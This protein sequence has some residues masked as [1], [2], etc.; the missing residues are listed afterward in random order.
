MRKQNKQFKTDSVNLENIVPLVYHDK[1]VGNADLTPLAQKTSNFQIKIDNSSIERLPNGSIRFP[2]SI[3]R[4]G[5]FSYITDGKIVR[6][7]RSPE[8]VF[9]P[10][11]ISTLRSSPITNDHPPEKI[12]PNNYSKFANGALSDSFTKNKN[13]NDILDTFVTANDN[14]L[15]E[16]I[17][18]G[19]KQEISCGYDC[20]VITQSGEYKGDF[21]DAVQKNITYNHVAIVQRGRAGR[22]V[23]IRFDDGYHIDSYEEKENIN[24]SQKE[25]MTTMK[26]NGKEFKCDEVGE[27][28]IEQKFKE[29][30]DKITSLQLTVQEQKDRE[31]DLQEKVTK[32]DTAEA[33]NAKLEKDIETMKTKNDEDVANRVNTAIK[34]KNYLKNDADIEGLE[35]IEIKKMVISQAFPNKDYSAK[36]DNFFDVLFETLD[37]MPEQ[38]KQSVKKDGRDLFNKPNFQSQTVKNDNYDN[39][40]S[41]YK[42]RSEVKA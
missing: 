10:T 15:I 41:S 33:L 17:L 32:L 5:I 12:N 2:A 14:Q 24:E 26:L 4:A 31:R 30:S 6:E 34:A 27:V 9:S 38:P 35:P 37:D 3:T 21:Y 20:Q 29:D 1:T 25:K 39:L 42:K 36:N 13:D 16:D 18:S 23:R 22:K 11:S 28:L 8:E 40:L 19:K 7:F